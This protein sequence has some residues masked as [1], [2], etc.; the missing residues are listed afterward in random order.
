M[1]YLGCWQALKYN[2]ISALLMKIKIPVSSHVYK[3]FTSPE[4]LGDKFPVEIRKDSLLGVLLIMIATKGPVELG[5]YYG[6]RLAPTPVEA[7]EVKYL[8]VSTKFPLREEFLLEEHLLYVGNAL[9]LVFNN[10]V[11]FFSMGYVSRM[12]SERGAIRLLY[13]RFGM[14]DDPVKQESL[15]AICKRNREKVMK[16]CKAKKS[17]PNLKK[18]A[19]NFTN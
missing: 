14:E 16:N 3:F 1:L 7:S 5:E 6:D 18:K 4:M 13:E 12:G 9:E 19:P 10:F 8:E 11:I 15:R 2:T 17:N